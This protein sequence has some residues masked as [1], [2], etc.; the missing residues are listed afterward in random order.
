VGI[1]LGDL[2]HE[3]SITPSLFPA[4]NKSLAVAKAMDQVNRKFG[5]YAIYYGGMHGKAEAV[6]TRIAF[7][8]VPDLKFMDA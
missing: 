6:T 4:N 2:V 3:R 1:V 7:G 5:R 8:V